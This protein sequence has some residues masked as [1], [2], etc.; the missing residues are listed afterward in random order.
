MTEILEL[1]NQL[2]PADVVVAK[3]RKGLGRILNH[4]IVY[5]GDTTFI[6]N[7]K[8]GVKTLTY[9]D[10]NEL[11]IDYEP[12]RIRKFNG[13]NTERQ[14]AL[15]RAYSRIGKSY[16]LLSYNCE[17]FANWVQKGKEIST[18]VDIGVAALI[19]GITYKIITSTNGKRKIKA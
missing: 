17:H 6:G 13:S 15:N 11:L 1:T 4:Y 8:E 10:L 18:Q 2:Q 12:M 16:N 19:V 9:L 3:K 5:V 14:Y 7:L